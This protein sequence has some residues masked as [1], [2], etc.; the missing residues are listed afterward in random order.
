MYYSHHTDV[1]TCVTTNH[2]PHYQGVIASGQL[3]QNPAIHL[4]SANSFQSISLLKVED[5]C[6]ICSLSFSAN[7][8]LLISLQMD[9]NNTIIIWKWEEGIDKSPSRCNQGRILDQ[10]NTGSTSKLLSSTRE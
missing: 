9:V 10:T 4:W 2:H 5:N 6:G 3:S 8:R 1:I 7:G